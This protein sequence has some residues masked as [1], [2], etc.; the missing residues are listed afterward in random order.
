M[1]ILRKRQLMKNLKLNKIKE[2]LLKRIL[3]SSRLIKAS[4]SLL[5]CYKSSSRHDQ[6]K[7]APATQ[8]RHTKNVVKMVTNSELLTSST[9]NKRKINHHHHHGAKIS[10][11]ELLSF[12]NHHDLQ[13]P[14]GI[15]A[16]SKKSI[17]GFLLG[18]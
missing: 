7:N 3:R 12:D 15:Y 4:S 6:T 18:N 5:I 1:T 2:R 17:R 9:I 14:S 13:W 16:L 10:H 8:R 11:K